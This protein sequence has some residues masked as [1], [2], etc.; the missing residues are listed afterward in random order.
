M[1]DEPISQFEFDADDVAPVLA[2]TLAGADDGELFLE[3]AVSEALVFDDGRLKSA[4]FDSNRG[5]GLRCVAG[6]SAGYAHSSDPTLAAVK[7]AAETAGAARRGHSG[8]L[9]DAPRGTNRKLYDAVDGRAPDV[10]HQGETPAG[11][12]RLLPDQG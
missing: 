10:R 12:R 1:S 4:S 3:T 9:A 11:D 2:D 5:F 7:R 8:I 6:E